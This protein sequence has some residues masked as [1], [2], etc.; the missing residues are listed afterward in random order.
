MEVVREKDKVLVYRKKPELLLIQTIVPVKT[1]DHCHFGR[2]VLLSLP[3]L[4][5]SEPGRDTGVISIY[6][7]CT[8]QGLVAK[9]SETR[10]CQFRLF[11]QVHSEQ[12]LHGFCKALAY[13]HPFLFVSDCTSA[14]YR[15]SVYVIKVT[16]RAPQ[17]R[18]L[19]TH[20]EADE[21][22]GLG[23]EV[24]TEEQDRWYRIQVRGVH[25][26]TLAG[27]V[28]HLKAKPNLTLRHHP[29]EVEAEYT[30]KEDMVHATKEDATK[31]NDSLSQS[32]EEPLAEA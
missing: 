14:D 31:E 1:L 26:A 13:A 2:I 25:R 16:E 9:T 21:C 20:T 15:G 22:V 29:L 5:I 28:I 24:R 11:C 30:T 8:K 27:F 10:S 32:P 18:L 23:L 17:L 12:K 4:F 6:R 3:Y 19:Y 7:W